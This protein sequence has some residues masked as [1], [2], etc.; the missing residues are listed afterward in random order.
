MKTF[1]AAA[2]LVSSGA[3]AAEPADLEFKNERIGVPPLSLADSIARGAVTPKRGP[4]STVS[5]GT[6]A[7]SDSRPLSPS[8]VPPR[9][10]SMTASETN[11]A[12]G[13]PGVDRSSGMPIIIPSDAVN[14]T[15]TIIPP[16]PAIDFKLKMKDPTPES[17]PPAAK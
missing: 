3:F 11:R 2:I 17:Q 16:N 5:P 7:D 14:Y 9:P 10:R 15:M 6:P 12:A 13:R 8:L 4:L 1:V